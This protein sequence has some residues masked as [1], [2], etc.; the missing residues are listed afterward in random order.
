MPPSG[1]KPLRA[2]F[3]RTKD[4]R[5]PVDDFIESMP[6]DKHKAAVD[7]QID[8]INALCTTAQPDLPFPHS[9]QVSGQF[10]ELRCHF[11]RTH[12]RILYRRS[13]D[14]VILLHAFVKRTAKIPPGEISEAEKNWDDFKTRMEA[15]PRIR[16]RAIGRDAPPKDR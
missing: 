2:V 15:K 7:S 1:P 5:E 11:G 3:Y 6:N 8:R 16:P 10:R 12:Y 9:S 13:R 4:G 14:V